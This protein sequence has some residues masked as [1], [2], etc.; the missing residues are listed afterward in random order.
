VQITT[1][2]L[3]VLGTQRKRHAMSVLK[4]SAHR[5]LL[6][7]ESARGIGANSVVHQSAAGESSLH[8]RIVM[9][10]V[11]IT[12]FDN[13]LWTVSDKAEVFQLLQLRYSALASFRIGTSGSASF[14]SEIRQLGVC[15]RSI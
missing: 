6:H 7:V 12:G 14:Q 11:E 9:S 2:N 3:H 10:V 1:Y 8:Q 15:L 13:Y 4:K 5:L